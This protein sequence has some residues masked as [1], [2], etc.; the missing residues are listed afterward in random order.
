M[1]RWER[2]AVNRYPL[3]SRGSTYSTEELPFLNASSQ[4]RPVGVTVGR[5]GRVFVTALYLSGNVWSPHC[6]SDLLMVT[7][8]DDPAEYPFE[9]YDVVTLSADQL[10]AE[11]SSLSWGRRSTA[12]KEILRGRSAA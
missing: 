8:A 5:G 6:Y 2:F 7:R 3:L 10:W 1:D 9:S 4:A 11:L 12:H